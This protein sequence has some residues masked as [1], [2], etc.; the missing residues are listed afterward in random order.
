MQKIMIPLFIFIAIL[1]T[2]SCSSDKKALTDSDIDSF[3]DED[4]DILTDSNTIEP[5]EVDAEPDEI[6]EFDD[7]EIIEIDDDTEF[8]GEKDCDQDLEIVFKNYAYLKMSG[9]IQS[10]ENVFNGSIFMSRLKG[11][12]TDI[13]FENGVYIDHT[14]GTII[15]LVQNLKTVESEEFGKI[16]EKDDAVFTFRP[17]A[18]DKMLY[19]G[20]YGAFFV[21]TKSFFSFNMTMEV[22]RKKCYIATDILWDYE[23]PYLEAIIDIPNGKIRGCFNDKRDF[24]AG[25][26]LKM[27]FLNK[28][29]DI[30]AAVLQRI[31]W[32]SWEET[33]KYGDPGFQ[34]ICTCYNENGPTA[35]TPDPNE[36]KCWE[37]DGPGG[38]E[39]KPDYVND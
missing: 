33:L 30:P 39:E 16:I 3:S 18:I 7:N 2:I 32:V 15:A 26:F 1:F 38:S 4:A 19:V 10:S 8:Q 17:D 36:V 12:Q 23:D 31:N 35:E 27:Q 9:I 28:I 13:E 20:A 37:Y 21:S 14:Y 11:D 5:D 24:K 22:L 29:T 25:D 6:T 34:N